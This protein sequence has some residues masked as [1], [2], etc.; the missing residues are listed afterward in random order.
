MKILKFK[1]N[2]KLVSS[3]FLAII[4]ISF[5][6]ASCEKTNDVLETAT[7]EQEGF[8]S[9]SENTETLIDENTVAEEPIMHMRFK[10][11]L[12]K[13]EATAKWE[14]E[15]KS[16]ME[17]Y[18]IENPQIAERG[19]STELFFSFYTKTGCQTDNN[20]DGSVY[21][22]LNF[23]SNNG[24][25]TTQ[26]YNLNNA[27]DDREKCDWDYY[28]YKR[29]PLN[30]QVITYA[31]ARWAQLALKGTDGWFP[32]DFDV[33]ILARDQTVPATGN[34]HIYSAPNTWLDSSS[35]SAWDYYYTGNTGFGRLNF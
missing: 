20:T 23:R 24:N 2:S 25:R 12:S 30:G 33:H 21:A 32:T 15:V 17:Q 35:S 14:T 4:A 6:L 16:F 10:G 27:G 19:V 1:L 31:Q 7:I 26:W 9:T 18:K 28:L 3:S 5:F 29:D 11:D 13:E 34:S 22:R 8:K